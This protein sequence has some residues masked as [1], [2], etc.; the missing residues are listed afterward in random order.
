MTNDKKRNLIEHKTGRV[1]RMDGMP[2]LQAEPP[3]PTTLPEFP[4]GDVLGI[5]GM[6]QP[7]AVEGTDKAK[8]ADDDAVRSQGSEGA[9]PKK[10]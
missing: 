10:Q 7:K 1:P 4:D 5:T 3:M 9:Q 6:M 8:H 2:N